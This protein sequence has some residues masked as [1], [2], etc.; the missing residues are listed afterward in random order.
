[1]LTLQKMFSCAMF[2][3]VALL[4]LAPAHAADNAWLTDFEAAK[5]AAAKDSKLIFM[6]IYADWCP[7][8]KM[9]EQ[10]TFPD[11]TVKAALS[12]FVLMKV[13]ADKEMELVE[14]YSDGSLPTLVVLDATGK[15][16]DS[17]MGFLDPPA[18]TEWLSAAKNAG[19]ELE[20]LEARV[21]AQPDDAAAAMLLVERYLKIREGAKALE[22]LGKLPE[23]AIAKLSKDDQANL[24][25]SK[26]IACYESEQ[27]EQGVEVLRSFKANHPQDP[28]AFTIDQMILQ[29]VYRAARLA[30][31]NGDID[32]A[33][34]GF[35]ELSKDTTIPGA[36]D[37]A[38]MELKRLDL[39]AKPGAALDVA[40]WAIGQ[41]VD[42]AVL[43]GKVVLIDFF[44]IS[45]PASELSRTAISA[46]IS[47]YGNASLAAVGVAMA[48]DDTENATADKIK[49]YVRDHEYLYPV[50]IDAELTRT[51]NAYTG[52]G[53]PWTA[54]LDS[55]GKVVYLDFFDEE[56]IGELLQKL[57]G[58]PNA[59]AAS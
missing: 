30:F 40:E 7:P 45:D 4:A 2:C 41:P 46:W 29:G 12:E 38:N 43:A 16:L 37:V 42:I 8:C 26:A 3:S 36:A 48:F 28:R 54:V 31:R 51:F 19:K 21:A 22:I 33:R 24:Q 49:T 15:M 47:R 27:F 39:F 5:A 56:R 25:Y 10:T 13:D 35:T 14:R 59:G 50:A 44:Q 53:S 58:E 18:F 1:M 55:A 23:A 34:A 11:P 57:L 32:K 17:T 6:D 20:A 52:M 9:L